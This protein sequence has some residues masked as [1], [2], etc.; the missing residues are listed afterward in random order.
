[1]V[2]KIKKFIEAVKLLNELLKE[3]CKLVA[4]ITIIIIMIV[5]LL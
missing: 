3:I 5:E 1:M 4:T 2:D